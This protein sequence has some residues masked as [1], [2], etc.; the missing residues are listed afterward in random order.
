MHDCS[1]NDIVEE[2]AELQLEEL[3]KEQYREDLRMQEDV[4]GA[5]IYFSQLTACMF[6]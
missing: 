2:K 1:G 4:W 3:W 6:A 5:I